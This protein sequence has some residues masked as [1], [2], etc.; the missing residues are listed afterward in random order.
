[1]STPD[2]FESCGPDSAITATVTGGVIN[3][4][5][6]AWFSQN[7]GTPDVMPKGEYVSMQIAY[8]AAH[9]ASHPKPASYSLFD[10]KLADL[11]QRGYEVIG[12]ILHKDGEY[13]LFDSS[14]RWLDK[15]KYDRL[16]HEQDGSLF[17]EKAAPIVEAGI[18]ISNL[19]RFYDF[20]DGMEQYA[21][22]KYLL[23]DDVREALA[24]K[25]AQ[26]AAS[27]SEDAACSLTDEQLGDLEFVRG[28]IESHNES[29]NL[30]M[31]E[32]TQLRAASVEAAR[33]VIKELVD[34]YETHGNLHITALL[35]DARGM[36]PAQT[37]APES[38]DDWDREAQ[39][40]S[41]SADTDPAATSAPVDLQTDRHTKCADLIKAI[42]SKSAISH[43]DKL[44]LL[45]CALTVRLMGDPRLATPVA[46]VP[47]IESGKAVTPPNCRNQGGICACRSGGS[48][49]GCA[50]ERQGGV[51]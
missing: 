8:A 40:Y 5:F 33:R 46:G 48:Y 30:V 32:L 28:Y 26:R 45:G 44:R 25:D 14:C 17:A 13:A 50:I 12:R 37:P 4:G 49:G 7:Y 6:D 16:M 20:G 35:E 24:Y 3:D 10:R 43:D 9:A 29:F 36:F 18:D 34:W 47:H 38:S 2:W 27:V 15:A 41:N 51:A 39:E 19:P 23:V 11:E 22:G 42:A 31:A 21:D 1:M